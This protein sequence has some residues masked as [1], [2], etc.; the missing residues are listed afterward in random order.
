MFSWALANP[1]ICLLLYVSLSCIY[2]INKKPV[3]LWRGYCPNLQ[4]S[5]CIKICLSI[6]TNNIAQQLKKSEAESQAFL[7]TFGQI[8]NQSEGVGLE[9]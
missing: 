2:I 8:L 7:Y 3:I 6:R 9:F 4:V 1:S 5:S